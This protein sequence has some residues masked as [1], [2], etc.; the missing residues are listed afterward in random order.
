MLD[1]IKKTMAAQG[2]DYERIIAS[3]GQTEAL[4]RRSRGKGFGLQ[5]HV[6]GLVLSQLSSNRRW[7]PIADNLDQITDI[8]FKFEPAKLKRADPEGLATSILSIGCGN[9]RIRK[10]ICALKHNIEVFEKIGDVDA[11]VTSLRPEKIADEFAHGKHKFK[12]IGVPLALE[13]L[14]NVGINT[15]KPDVHIRR[16]VGPKRF[17]LTEREPSEDEARA[18]AT[19]LAEKSAHAPI[20]VDNL[21]WIFAAKDYAA[22]CTANP[23]CN[24]CLVQDCKKWK[25]AHGRA[26]R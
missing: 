12:E 11:Y 13:Y 19:T 16:M 5:D 10:Q 22:I 9:R 23:K 6:R 24:I 4:E 14:K 8:F 3:F 15:I 1:Q 25:R 17:G 26:T 21:L 2:I 7:G 18:A 20:Y